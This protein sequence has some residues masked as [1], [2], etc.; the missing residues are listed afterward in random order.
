[1]CTSGTTALSQRPPN[2]SKSPQTTFSQTTKKRSQ[3]WKPQTL[4]T[5]LTSSRRTLTLTTRYSS[6]NSSKT[7][8]Q[9]R[10]NSSSRRQGTSTR[11]CSRWRRARSRGRDRRRRA[12]RRRGGVVVGIRQWGTRPVQRPYLLTRC[13]QSSRG[14]GRGQIRGWRQRSTGSKSRPAVILRAQ[15][16]PLPSVGSGRIIWRWVS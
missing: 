4:C 11:D 15:S 1:M 5:L 16:N 2:W 6:S 14:P 3:T 8:A 13:H 9:S 7:R 12:N 10:S